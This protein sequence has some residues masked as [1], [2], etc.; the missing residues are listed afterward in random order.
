MEG[1]EQTQPS[2]PA[3]TESK[4]NAEHPDS[5]RTQTTGVEPMDLEDYVIVHGGGEAD[6]LA[7]G[8]A[9]E[10]KE[11]KEEHKGAETESESAGAQPPA[12]K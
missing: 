8:K 7:Q 6:N 2:A 10:T 3:D 1:A 12:P 11:K 4:S 9:T 5:A